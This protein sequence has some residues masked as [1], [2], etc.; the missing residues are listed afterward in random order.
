MTP[1]HMTR[2]RQRLCPG[3]L[4]QHRGRLLRHADHI[5]RHRRGRGGTTPCCADAA[6]APSSAAWSRWSSPRR[7]TA[8]NIGERT[9]VAGS[10]KFKRLI[11]EGAYEA[12][13]VAAQQIENDAAHRRQLTTPCWTVKRP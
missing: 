3:R 6:G 11:A 5:K 12:T 7:P 8:I 2:V 1:R 9:N 10:A 4:R 13:R